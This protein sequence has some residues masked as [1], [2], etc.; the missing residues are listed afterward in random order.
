MCL[1]FERVKNVRKLSSI[2]LHE[3]DAYVSLPP[4]QHK[5]RANVTLLLSTRQAQGV[6]TLPGLWRACCRRDLPAADSASATTSAT[7][8]SQRCSAL[9]RSTIGELHQVICCDG[10][11]L[12]SGSLFP[13]TVSILKYIVP[14]LGSNCTRSECPHQKH[15]NDNP[16]PSTNPNP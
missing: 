1:G 3:K 12:F 9:S 8:P 15:H 5:P 13:S 10:L 6:S 16:S 14:V 7:I 11:M 4:L 2:S